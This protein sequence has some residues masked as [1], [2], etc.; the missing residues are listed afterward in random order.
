M[1]FIMHFIPI[2]LLVFHSHLGSVEHP[3]VSGQLRRNVRNSCR[4]D[5]FRY[6]LNQCLTILALLPATG[7]LT[8][9]G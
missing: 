1:H 6:F 9:Q 5:W 4:M 8:P 7:M 3:R 2:L